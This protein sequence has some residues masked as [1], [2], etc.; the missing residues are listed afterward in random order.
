MSIKLQL[1]LTQAAV[2][3]QAVLFGAHHAWAA[4]WAWH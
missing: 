3:L 1:R 4:G 2:V